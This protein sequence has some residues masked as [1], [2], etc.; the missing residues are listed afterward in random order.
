MSISLKAWNQQFMRAS[1]YTVNSEGLLSIADG[2]LT[3]YSDTFS[4][5]IDADD[6]L[7]MQNPEINFGIIRSSI[8]LVIER[9]RSISTSDTSFFRIWN[10]PANKYRLVFMLH[11]LAKK[12]LTCF[13]SDTYLNKKTAVALDDTT[14]IDFLVTGDPLSANERRFQLIYSMDTVT[15]VQQENL[16]SSILIYPNPV[17]GNKMT[18]K[19]N[20]HLENKYSVKLVYL[21]G[22]T[23]N[24]PDLITVSGQSNYEIKLPEQLAS[25]V[26]QLILKDSRNKPLI[27]SFYRYN[28]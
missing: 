10:I 12:G 2:N 9:R 15:A 16:P 5:A 28:K 21:D 17:A 6:I 23:E 26:Y 11:D 7:K 4:S 22:R 1:L 27:M 25:S 14:S 13:L 20:G 24:L 18:I 3:E 19:L 8:N